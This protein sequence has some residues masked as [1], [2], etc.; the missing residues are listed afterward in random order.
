MAFSTINKSTSFQNNILWTGDGLTG[1]AVNG[2]GFK[3]DAVFIKCRSN[4]DGH[5]EYDILRG[6]NKRIAISETEDEATQTEGLQSF[7]ADGF[8]L[9][10][11]NAS[12]ADGR[13]YVSWNW[14]ANGA[15]VL[16]EVGDLDST[17]S[18]NTTSKYSICSY[19]G[20]GASGATV[21]HGLGVKP[22]VI[23]IKGRT[24]DDNW[25]MYHQYNGATKGLATDTSNAVA[26]STTYFN[27]TAPTADV[28]SLGNNGKCNT[29]GGTFIAYCFAD[30]PGYFKAGT[31]VGN[32]N[33][34]GTFVYTGFRPSFVIGKYNASTEDWFIFDDKRDPYNVNYHLLYGNVNNAEYT[35]ASDRNDFLSNGF[36]MRTTDGKENANGA[37][38]IYLAFG[39]P[40]ISNSGV[41]ATA[42]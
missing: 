7:T 18:V 6:A 13:T 3:P 32:G 35:G 17:V 28:F 39:Q 16:N 1:R 2:V 5:A 11:L 34:N 25:L 41:C 29:D 31:F 40:I 8:T 19:T 42:R 27:D 24:V 15:G 9:G 23:L 21:G 10:T 4:G 33:V 26:T 37:R 20:N 38:Y 22:S 14:L 30:L 36:K 12:N